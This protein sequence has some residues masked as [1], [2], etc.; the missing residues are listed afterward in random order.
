M[1]LDTLG[2]PIKNVEVYTRLTDADSWK[3][4]KQ[5]KSPVKMTTRIDLNVRPLARPPRHLRAP[6]HNIALGYTDPPQE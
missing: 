3:L 4:V 5:F 6:A 1:H 2:N